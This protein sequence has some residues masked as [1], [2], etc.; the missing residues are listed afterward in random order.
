MKYIKKFKTHSGYE[1]YKDS[2]DYTTPNVSYCVEQT[3]VHYE[4]YVRDY[5][6]EYLTFE[7]VEDT[8][9]QF[10][11]DGLSYSLDNGDTWVSLAA[12]TATPTVSAGNKIM[13]KGEI[14][15][16]SSGGIGKF[17]STGEFNAS[18]NI[19]SLLYGDNFIGQTDLTGKNE[20][21]GYIFE[22]NTDLIDVG[23][24]A[25]PATTLSERCY[26]NMFSGCAGLTTAPE[27]PA[28]TLAEYCYYYMFYGCTSLTTAPEL[29]ATTLA[30]YCYANMFG[31][32]TGL[33][34]APE[35]PATTL[36][37][38]CYYYMFLG[39]TSLTAG[40]ELPA[41]TLTNGCYSHMFYGCT[42][43]NYIKAMF[44]TTP[45]PGYTINW[46]GG[47]ASTGTFVKNSAATWT[48]TGAN[49]IPSGWT[50]QTAS[51]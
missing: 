50:V 44:T 26:H 32:C 25:L 34:T 37:E 33:A 11:K 48:T 40:P 41:T 6:K 43:L 42:N 14:T 51:A 2:E 39:C 38:Y 16:P 27:L 18:G 1:T 24:M 7:A 9:F 4:K 31:G 46:V 29:P 35:L 17:S 3:E 22:G 45:S 49:G 23:N 10:T 8:T 47:V 36:A 19:M 28:T 5:S 20:T 21:F 30:N 15:P 12:D 13:F